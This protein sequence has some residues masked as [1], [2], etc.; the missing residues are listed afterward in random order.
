MSR[1]LWGSESQRAS[2]T[3]LWKRV[4]VTAAAKV[5]VG[6]DVQELPDGQQLFQLPVG[7][8]ETWPLSW[9]CGALPWLW[10][11]PSFLP[12]PTLHNSLSGVPTA[13]LYGG[14]PRGL[15]VCRLDLWQDGALPCLSRVPH[16]RGLPSPGPGRPRWER[17]Q[18][19]PGDLKDRAAKSRSLDAGACAAFVHPRPQQCLRGS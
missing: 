11:D 2:S 18:Q 16:P 1:D 7:R 10:T 6:V 15:T 8:L 14:D 4:E 12:I 9:S 3:P 13:Q 17:R 19:L 5:T